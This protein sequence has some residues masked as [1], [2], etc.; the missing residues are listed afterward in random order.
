MENASKALLI[1]GAILIALIII[2]VG[3]YMYNITKNVQQEIDAKTVADQLAKFNQQFEAYDK[4]AM[5]AVEIITIVNKVV[6]YNTKDPDMSA[7]DMIKVNMT[8]NYDLPAG[9]DG[10]S[11]A[12]YTFTT[13]TI[14]KKI[15]TGSAQMTDFKEQRY[16]KCAGI[17]YNKGKVSELSFVEITQEV[18]NS[19]QKYKPQ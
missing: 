11:R 8:I 7:A 15:I 3:I 13:E 19:T 16:F 18:L 2:S 4:K 17:K 9:G 1:A 12:T 14:A 10:L 6:A 5:R